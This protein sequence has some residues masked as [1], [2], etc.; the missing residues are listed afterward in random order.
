MDLILSP[1]MVCWLHM[2]VGCFEERED[3]RQG[4]RAA[5]SFQ[6]PPQGRC[7]RRE[8]SSRR[9]GL[10]WTEAALIKA[11]GHS[12]AMDLSCWALPCKFRNW[13]ISILQRAAIESWLHDERPVVGQTDTLTGRCSSNAW[14]SCIAG[15]S[16]GGLLQS[17]L[18]T[19][20]K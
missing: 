11:T 16:L 19:L 17:Q 4:W 5:P 14:L 7:A 9:Q 10:R 6:G 20:N 2:A 13:R 18:R 15:F 12:M 3:R 8:P 1:V